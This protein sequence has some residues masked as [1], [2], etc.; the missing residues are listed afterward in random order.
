MDPVGSKSPAPDANALESLIGGKLAVWVGAIAL[1]LG[2]VFLVKYS[3]DQGLLGPQLRIIGGLA[4]G[5]GLGGA[6][7]RL[8]DRS[9][10][11][12]Q[13]LAAA[14][15]IDI[16][17][18]LWAAVDVFEL[19]PG[20][21]GWLGMVA[22]TIAAV[23]L[24]LRL[25]PLV[26]VLGLLGAFLAPLLVGRHDP[27]PVGLFAYLLALQAGGQFVARRRRWMWASAISLGAGALWV[28]AQL[29][30]DGGQVWPGL[31][32]LGSTAVFVLPELIKPESGKAGVAGVWGAS[33]VGTLLLAA[34]LSSAGF[35]PQLWIFFGLLASG[36]G[37]LA[38]YREDYSRLGWLSF[39]VT[40][41]MMLTHSLHGAW[42][43]EQDLALA[44][45]MGAVFAAIGY[46]G[47]WKGSG[48]NIY[49]LVAIAPAAFVVAV[50]PKVAPAFIGQSWMYLLLAAGG[51]YWLLLLPALVL[52][53]GVGRP[54]MD[55][56]LIPAML[57]PALAWPFGLDL[58]WCVMLWS[59]QLVGVLALDHKFGFDT[60]RWFGLL[61]IVVLD[62][63]L[64]SPIMLL[65]GRDMGSW[66]LANWPNAAYVAAFCACLL[67]RRFQPAEPAMRSFL[68]I[69]ASLLVLAWAFMNI[70][71]SANGGVL[72]TAHVG[73]LEVSAHV[74]AVLLMANWLM[75]RAPHMSVRNIDLEVTNLR[76]LGVGLALS[77]LIGGAVLL[78]SSA[79]PWA[80]HELVSGTYF[81][82]T[83]LIG[84]GVPAL[85]MGLLS[86][87][88]G[89]RG[90]AQQR[91]V[92]WYATGGVVVLLT[93]LE[94]RHLFHGASL[95]IGSAG[96][97]EHY[98]YSLAMALLAMLALGLGVR[99]DSRQLRVI[100]LVGM[101]ACSLKVF[102]YDMRQ[103]QG[104]FRVL[105]FL[106]LGASLMALGYIYN[107]FG[108]KPRPKLPETATETLELPSYSEILTDTAPLEAS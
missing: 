6:A 14:A 46:S 99:R 47:L 5:L 102:T 17:A 11:V 59:A 33:V 108:P 86:R 53:Q 9:N 63:C 30:G 82:N 24:S 83:I 26:A 42:T 49:S 48:S 69:S 13:G 25:G 50:L 96:E 16:Y 44:L 101:L 88:L 15:V 89:L 38:V 54:Q 68:S 93:L 75:S 90:Y 36:L 94:V 61:V 73:A 106:G 85:F 60:T 71:H 28:I 95:W 79:N 12:A 51:V 64:L 105:S 27:N 58:Q 87:Q 29:W 65:M 20:W 67:A 7:W 41:A 92:G 2:G 1:A 80:R 8:R 98:A 4:L 37:V 23:G 55:S 10:Y 104:I 66:P 22:T 57:L 107:R 34:N 3:I 81:L 103:L 19:I 72:M 21:L 76:G 52:R 62:L 97:A 91:L 45:G 32:L 39:G 74:L 35:S 100:A 78:C 77:G 84:I 70:H 18:C 43:P 56:L 31:F 40:L